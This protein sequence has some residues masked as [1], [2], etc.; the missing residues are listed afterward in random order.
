MLVV[1]DIM[2]LFTIYRRL[3]VLTSIVPDG[4]CPVPLL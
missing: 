3:E 4:H 1:G 2:I